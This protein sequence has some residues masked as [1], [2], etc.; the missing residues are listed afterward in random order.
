MLEDDVS[1]DAKGQYNYMEL[2]TMLSPS[3]SAHPLGSH[4]TMLAARAGM[5]PNG[6]NKPLNLP[7]SINRLSALSAASRAANLSS[8]ANASG[9]AGSGS[10]SMN[11]TTSNLD[12]NG[13][14]DVYASGS[15][16]GRDAVMMT[17]TSNG[18]S[19]T[20]GPPVSPIRR[21]SPMRSGTLSSSTSTRSIR[22]DV[23]I[24]ASGGP[25]TPHINPALL[26]NVETSAHIVR[27]RRRLAGILGVEWRRAK[28][29][30]V[31]CDQA[32]VG[33]VSKKDVLQTI[34]TV[35]GGAMVSHS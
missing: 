17:S 14:E 10:G 26:T 33:T 3:A 8:T 31:D 20:S 34:R 30:C 23:G 21:L 7:A 18:L 4:S 32:K 22:P 15:S 5:N 25:A 9:G 19:S 11:V 1:V 12:D 2:M 16:S 13:S 28:K 27:L 6:S 24:S 29:R 35:G